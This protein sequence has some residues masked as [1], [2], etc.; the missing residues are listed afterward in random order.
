MAALTLLE[1]SKRGLGTELD[2]AVVEIFARNSPILM[3][4]PFRT[5][6]GNAL[7]YNRE[8]TLPGVAFRGVNEAFSSSV[9]VLNPIT[10]SLT[11]IGGDLEVDKFIIDTEGAD[12]RSIHEAMKLK[13]IA[14]DW[15][16]TFFK[17]DVQ[18]DVKE[19]DGLQTRLVGNQLIDAGVSSGGDA[20]SLGVVDELIDAVNDPTHLAMNKTLARRFSAAARDTAVGGFITFG[21]DEFGRRIMFY[22]D[23]PILVIQSLQGLDTVL[24]FTEANPGGGS[25]ASTSMY[26]LSITPNGIQ[27]IQNKPMEARDLGEQDI[28]PVMLTRVEWYAGMMIRH[29]RAGGRLRGIKN[30]AIVK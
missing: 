21:K 30:A 23:L 27:G 17:G 16:T 2:Q 6:S 18:T 10:E 15:Q 19:F 8:Q 22:G 7:K 5:I 24:P 11:I 4:L 25:A 3:V 14:E 29:G 13:A 9:G 20:L 1:A 28:K 26:C 12:I